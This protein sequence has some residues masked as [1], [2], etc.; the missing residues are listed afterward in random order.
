MC[1]PKSV[2]L[3]AAAAAAGVGVGDARS[4]MLPALSRFWRFDAELGVPSDLVGDGL[5][6]V[7]GEGGASRLPLLFNL[8]DEN[9]AIAVGC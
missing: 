9:E 3:A 4:L 6:R 1:V 7:E 8:A 2:A 5:E